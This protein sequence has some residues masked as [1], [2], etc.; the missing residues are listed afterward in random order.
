[1]FFSSPQ[2]FCSYVHREG[3]VYR[4]NTGHSTHSET[5]GTPAPC[6]RSSSR[7]PEVF[8]FRKTSK[9][10]NRLLRVFPQICYCFSWLKTLNPGLVFW[11]GLLPGNQKPG[12]M[13][14]SDVHGGVARNGPG[15][16]RIKKGLACSVSGLVLLL[17]NPD[18]DRENIRTLIGHDIRV[19][20][21]AHQV[22]EISSGNV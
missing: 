19:T 9:R 12:E 18:R 3:G 2:Y 16:H 6:K 7:I 20:H 15:Y 13:N 5:E 1:M 8:A 4:R 21:H 11:A 22:F 14:G 10:M 17:V